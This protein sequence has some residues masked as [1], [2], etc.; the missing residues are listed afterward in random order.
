M[1]THVSEAAQKKSCTPTGPL[2]D[3]AA[4]AH[5]HHTKRDS[6]VKMSAFALFVTG[7]IANFAVIAFAQAPCA[8]FLPGCWAIDWMACGHLVAATH[9]R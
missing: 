1:S 9:L 7:R 3:K 8:G 4:H 2:T 6:I 5:E